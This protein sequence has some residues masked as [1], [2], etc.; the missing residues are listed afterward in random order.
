MWRGSNSDALRFRLLLTNKSPHLPNRLPQAVFILHQRHSHVLLTRRSKAAAW[1]DRYLR[2]FQQLH[3]EIYRRQRARE[4]AWR[5]C[6]DEH[7]GPRR[8]AWQA[9]LAQTV[10]QQVAA[11]LID[12]RLSLNRRFRVAKRDNRGDLNRLKQAVIV[13][14]LDD[15]QSPHHLGIAAA[16]ADSPAGHVI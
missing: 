8:F 13:V 14:A 9:L 7:A 3:C 6:R 1:A 5:I 12:F 15:A 4:G 2:L 16:I 10:E 11:R